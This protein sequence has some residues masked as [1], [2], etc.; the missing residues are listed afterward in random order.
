MINALASFLARHLTRRTSGRVL[1]PEVDGL[2]SIAIL[3]VVFFH[4]NANYGFFAGDP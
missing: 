2:R 3:S 4:A 1:I